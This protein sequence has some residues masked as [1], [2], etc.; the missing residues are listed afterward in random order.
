MRDDVEEAFE[1]SVRRW[2]RAY[3]RRWRMTF[4]AE[5]VATAADLA[6]PGERRFPLREGLRV[7]WSGL[8]LRRRERPSWWFRTSYRRFSGRPRTQ[9]EADWVADD[10]LSPWYGLVRV[11]T[12]FVFYVVLAL[13][14]LWAPGRDTSFPLGIFAALA[15]GTLAN[16]I[17]RRAHARRAWHAA[18]PDAPIPAQIA[19]RPRRRGR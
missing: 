12:G 2:L 5:F 16:A 10:I 17:P 1:R 18:F 8:R 14:C 4:G 6:V 9:R 19:R 15:L 3:P 13:V 11:G 7:A